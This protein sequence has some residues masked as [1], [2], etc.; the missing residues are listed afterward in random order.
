MY[1]SI[2]FLLVCILLISGCSSD[3]TTSSII[4]T[5]LFPLTSGNKLEYRMYDI[6]SS[7]AEITGTS[8]KFTR[9]IGSPVYIAGVYASPVFETTYNSSNAVESRDTTYVYKSATDDTISYY[10]KITLPLTDSQNITMYKWVPMFLR[11]A[12]VATYFSML[13]TTVTVSTTI[14]GNSYPV[15]LRLNI[16]NYIYNQ[17]KLAVPE[18]TTGYTTNEIELFYYLYQSGV[19]FRQGTYYQVWFADGVGPIKERRFYLEKNKGRSI[20]LSAKTL[21]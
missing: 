14:N 11:S 3:S 10:L 13:D 2:L 16:Q 21:K 9:E 17:E 1:R 12:S 18:N 7:Y 8:R 5:N 4:G 19:A 20:E 15:P 6:D